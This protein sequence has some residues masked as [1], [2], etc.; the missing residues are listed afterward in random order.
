[1]TDKLVPPPLGV[2]GERHPVVRGERRPV[3]RGERRLAVRRSRRRG[4]TLLEVIGAFSAAT[5]LMLTVFWLQWNGADGYSNYAQQRDELRARYLAGVMRSVWESELERARGDYDRLGLLRNMGLVGTEHPPDPEGTPRR[6]NASGG[7]ELDYPAGPEL[8]QLYTPG[9]GLNISGGLRASGFL[10]GRQFTETGTSGTI[11]PPADSIWYEDHGFLPP[12][13][14]VTLDARMVDPTAVAEDVSIVSHFGR[15]RPDALVAG[16]CVGDD[17]NPRDAGTMWTHDGTQANCPTPTGPTSANGAFLERPKYGYVPRRQRRH[18]SAAGSLLS[19]ARC[20]LEP[21]HVGNLN[22]SA[23][24]GSPGSFPSGAGQ[25]TD[26]FLENPQIIYPFIGIHRF[27]NLGRDVLVTDETAMTLVLRTDF[28]EPIPEGILVRAAELLAPYGGIGLHPDHELSY[29]RAASGSPSVLGRLGINA[30][31]RGNNRPSCLRHITAVT[32][33]GGCADLYT[34]VNQAII[35][36]HGAWRFL[37]RELPLRN[38]GDTK[39]HSTANELPAGTVASASDRA[40]NTRGQ[41]FMVGMFGRRS[42]LVELSVA[43]AQEV[44]SVPTRFSRKWYFPGSRGLVYDQDAAGNLSGGFGVVYVKNATITGDLEIG[45]DMIIGGSQE[46]TELIATGQSGAGF[47]PPV[48]YF[49]NLSDGGGSGDP[50][51]FP[52]YQ[53]F[54]EDRANE[55]GVRRLAGEHPRR[56]YYGRVERRQRDYYGSQRRNWHVE[57]GYRVPLSN[58]Y[59]YGFAGVHN[60]FGGGAQEGDRNG[61]LP[62][63]RINVGYARPPAIDRRASPTSGSNLYYPGQ[64]TEGLVYNFPVAGSTLGLPRTPSM[65][66]AWRGFPDG[67]SDCEQAIYPGCRVAD[68]I[69][70]RGERVQSALVLPETT[71]SVE[72]GNIISTRGSPYQRDAGR[73]LDQRNAPYVPS[74]DLKVGRIGGL[75]GSGF[76]WNRVH[77]LAEQFPVGQYYDFWDRGSFVAERLP[78]ALRPRAVGGDIVSPRGAPLE[79]HSLLGSTFAPG[80]QLEFVPPPIE[81]RAD[82]GNLP[83]RT[84]RDLVTRPGVGAWIGPRVGNYHPDY[85]INVTTRITGQVRR[86][87]PDVPLALFDPIAPDVL[88]GYEPAANAFGDPAGTTSFDFGAG[89]SSPFTVK[90]RPG[91]CGTTRGTDVYAPGATATTPDPNPCPPPSP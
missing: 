75:G 88:P 62:S 78:T 38:P 65:P 55:R 83:G 15:V 54:R 10:G 67:V 47:T 79:I 23:N 61:T 26:S 3:V 50:E 5:I 35:G 85:D 33:A 86:A 7:V 28:A 64:I 51:L 6:I 45:T 31:G 9:S 72:G 74:R 82:A 63:D 22:A 4:F 43:A 89:G 56:A 87:R 40:L 24:C 39:I 32:P 59:D 60:Q 58:Q 48:P 91:G 46:R 66:S 19:N 34:A 13:R 71:L 20:V 52:D 77:A 90:I 37:A 25:R 69:N 29:G 57:D 11:S 16:L 53:A 84:A 21:G 81:E 30:P 17:G 14:R 8:R 73:I 76:A 12:G 2:R 80:S 41:L 44:P 1:M 70:S 36:P 27:P 42:S 68:V 18:N 49:D